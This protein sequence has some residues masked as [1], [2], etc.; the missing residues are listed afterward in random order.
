MTTN[1]DMLKTSEDR[2]LAAIDI[3]TANIIKADVDARC[4]AKSLDCTPEL[5]TVRDMVLDLLKDL[6]KEVTNNG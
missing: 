4:E 1:Q 5:L 3:I 2:F 6:R